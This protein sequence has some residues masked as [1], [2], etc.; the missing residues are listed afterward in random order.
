MRIA[1]LLP[2][3]TEIVCSLG[4]ED[5]LVAVTHECDFP[6]SVRTKPVLTRSVLSAASTGAEVDHHIREL[7][8]QGSSIY[9]LDAD[10]LAALHPDLILTQELCEV[11]A[12]SYPIVE[13]AARRLGSSPQLV[14]LEPESLEDVFQNILFVGR[15]VG[16]PDAAED[17]CDAL[18]RRVASVEQR[19]AGRRA[20]R[21][22]CLEWVDPPFNCGH[23]TPELVTIAGGDER[24]GVARQPAYPLRWEEV[25]KADPEVVVVMA[26]GFSLE[27]SLREVEAARGC[28]DALRAETWVVDGNAFFSRPGPRLV[29]SVEIMAGILH[30]DAV[31]PPPSSTARPLERVSDRA[32]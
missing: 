26:C 6:E 22:V 23:W 16:R 13:R 30:P 12:V 14:S 29:E 1:S 8:H 28:F 7:V 31:D 18:R 5:E 4:L 15:L 27:R 2:S 20:R 32:L 17:V 9:A 21:V 3:A 10:L 24:L 11:C 19:V 25:M